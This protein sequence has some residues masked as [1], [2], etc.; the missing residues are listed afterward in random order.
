MQLEEDEQTTRRRRRRRP[1]RF[2]VYI[3]SVRRRFRKSMRFLGK[4]VILNVAMV[5]K[6][7]IVVIDRA[8][9]SMLPVEAEAD[10]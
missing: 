10:M 5:L 8:G 2:R 9:K 3:A 6:A 4:R 1:G 7:Q